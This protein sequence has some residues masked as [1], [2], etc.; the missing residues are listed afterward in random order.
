VQDERCAGANGGQLDARGDYYVRADGYWGRYV[1]Y[2]DP[3]TAPQTCILRVRAGETEFDPGYL[4]PLEE[5]TGSKINFPWFHVSGSQYIAWAWDNGA[6]PPTDPDE[7]WA[8]TDFR[9]L[10]VDIERRTSEPYPDLEGTIIVSSAERELDGVKYYEWSEVGY[11]D[12]GLHA[13][14]VQLRPD[15]IVRKFSLPSLWALGRIR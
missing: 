9:P 15:G 11:V 13:D 12:D 2:A 6:T 7:Y 3:A 5:L 1:A 8:S 4:L 14:I 10:L